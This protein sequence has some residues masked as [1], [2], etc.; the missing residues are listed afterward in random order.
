MVASHVSPT[1]D[2]AWTQVCALTGNRTSDPLVHRPHTQST[3]PHQSWQTILIFAWHT[4][5]KEDRATRGDR[6]GF[7]ATPKAEKISYLSIPKTC[8][9]LVDQFWSIWLLLCINGKKKKKKK[10]LCRILK[11]TTGEKTIKGKK[12]SQNKNKNKKLN[13]SHTLKKKAPFS[14][15]VYQSFCK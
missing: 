13:L 9:T 14:K 1:G 10:S 6:L 2:P 11:R 3:E 5:M 12:R 4:G 15:R 8:S 7:S